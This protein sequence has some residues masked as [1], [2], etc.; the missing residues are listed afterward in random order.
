MFRKL[1]VLL[2]VL[3]STLTLAVVV[4]DDAG[5]V[6][7]FSAVPER[8]VSLSPAATRFLIFLGLEDRIVGVTDYDS[9]EAERVGAMVPVNVEKV[10]AL[11]PDLVLMFG[12][13]QLPEVAKLERV[14][15]KVLVINPTSLD[16]IIRDVVL[17]GTIFGERKLAVEKAEELKNKMLEIGKKPTTF[18][19][20][21]VRRF[22]I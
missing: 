22:C 9:Y 4:V 11:N 2:F 3:M 13:F 10:V 1:G 7:E 16:D 17:L 8:V 15:L 6:V 20:R 21:S 14:G 19:P 18:L 5:R 12:G